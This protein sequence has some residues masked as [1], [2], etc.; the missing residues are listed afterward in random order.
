[1]SQV[2]GKDIEY[3]ARLAKLKVSQTEE[4]KYTTQ[5]GEVLS[6]VG[7]LGKLPLKGVKETNQGK[8]LKNVMAR[9]EVE[10]GL[11]QEEAIGGAARKHEGYVMVGAILELT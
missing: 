5:L 3:L 8:G 2:T 6:Y 10:K 1:M 9:D 11:E 4:K 7:Q